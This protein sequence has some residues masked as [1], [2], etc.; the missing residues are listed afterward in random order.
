MEVS[1][2][3]YYSDW[4]HDQVVSQDQDEFKLALLFIADW[5]LHTNKQQAVA[6][7]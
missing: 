6:G 3:K 4:V 1:L 5:F 7:R 2:F